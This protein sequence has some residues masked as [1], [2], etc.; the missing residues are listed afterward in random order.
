MI[1]LDEYKEY[2]LNY[3]K[4]PI[5]ST[6]ERKKERMIVLEKRYPDS[7]LNKVID[8]TYN[9]VKDMFYFETINKS[10]YCNFE[11][12][13]DT[14]F[15]IRLNITGGGYSDYL[16]KDVNNRVISSYILKR[17]FGDMLDIEIK[18]YEIERK[19][20]DDV[21][22]FDYHYFLYMQWFQIDVDKLKE[23]IYGKEKILKLN[24]VRNSKDK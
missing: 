1:S 6:L 21:Y 3:Y 7:F 16:Y 24:K 11:V 19:T 2:L 10:G 17:V 5:D 13:D 22:S 23:N 18:N 8:D 14:S 20:D 15:G 9:F 12:N 4:Y